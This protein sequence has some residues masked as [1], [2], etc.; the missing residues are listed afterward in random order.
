MSRAP[1]MFQTDFPFHFWNSRKNEKFKNFENLTQ[2]A[3]SKVDT[4]SIVIASK[5]S[6][7][8]VKLTTKAYC[9]NLDCSKPCNREHLERAWGLKIALRTTLFFSRILNLITSSMVAFFARSFCYWLM[10]LAFHQWQSTWHMITIRCMDNRSFFRRFVDNFDFFSQ[11]FIQ[12]LNNANPLFRLRLIVSSWKS[13]VM[14]KTLS[15]RVNFDPNALPR[16][17][18]RATWLSVFE[19]ESKWKIRHCR[20]RK[21]DSVAKHSLISISCCAI[22]GENTRWHWRSFWQGSS[23]GDNN[24]M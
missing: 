15:D 9:E 21:F 1:D 10:S 11:P 16:T 7:I 8:I 12:N 19:K 23:N 6:L 5:K 20:L 4:H 13:I 22:T 2:G 3:G 14:T 17:K 18:S 24:V